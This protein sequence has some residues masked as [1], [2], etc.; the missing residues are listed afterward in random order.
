MGASLVDV[1]IDNHVSW[2]GPRWCHCRHP[3]RCGISTTRTSKSGLSIRKRSSRI[4]LCE[5]WMAA[6]LTILTP[7]SEKR[8]AR[9]RLGCQLAEFGT[10]TRPESSSNVSSPFTRPTSS[11]RAKLIRAT[12]G[13]VSI[14]QLTGIT[15]MSTSSPGSSGSWA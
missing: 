2:E 1:A 10:L 7:R 3:T 13:F 12:R 6:H 11:A 15:S 14:I 5:W 9:H 4:N 8:T